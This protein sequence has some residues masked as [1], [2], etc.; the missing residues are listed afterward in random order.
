MRHLSATLAALA[1]LASAD[2]ALAQTPDAPPAWRLYASPDGCAISTRQGGVFVLL[3][4]NPEGKQ[5]LR[6][7]HPDLA[8][9]DRTASPVTLTI[10]D[11]QLAFEGMGARTSDGMPGF[12]IGSRRDLRD[13]FGAGG[14]A[15][16]AIGGADPVVIDLEGLPEALE[17]LDTCAATLVPRDPAS[18]VAVK[19]RMTRAPAIRAGDLPLEGAT[20]REVGWRLTIAP[21]GSIADCEIVRS[22]GSRALDD[23]V[24]RLLRTDSRFEPGKNAAGKPVTATFQSR[25]TF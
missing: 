13:A 16:V 22:S 8:I 17:Q 7:H 2:V 23:E 19:P 1:V 15:E 25:V 4:V 20:R 14:I 5:G 21:D 11:R 3:N 6:I 24:C 10:G 18:I 9:P 12:I